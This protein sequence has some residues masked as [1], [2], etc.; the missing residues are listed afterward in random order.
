MKYYIDMNF[1]IYCLSALKTIGGEP[2][3]ENIII[4][5]LRPKIVI[6]FVDPAKR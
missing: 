3:S 2:Q 5:A 1:R 4:Y 6:V